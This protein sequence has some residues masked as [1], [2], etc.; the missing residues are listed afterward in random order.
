M[1][2]NGHQVRCPPHHDED[3]N[4]HQKDSG[5]PQHALDSN[6]RFHARTVAADWLQLA[7]WTSH[8]SPVEELSASSKRQL[9]FEAGS[10]AFARQST[11]RTLMVSCNLSDER[12]AEAD[13]VAGRPHCGGALERLKNAF[14]LLFKNA[15]APVGNLDTHVTRINHC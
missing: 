13:A 8:C 15:R 9:H 11:H 3:A 12:Q 2:K 5:A 10:A 4:Q 6:A 14:A 1:D 7:P